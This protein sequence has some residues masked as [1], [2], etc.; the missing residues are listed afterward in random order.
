MLVAQNEREQIIIQ[1][2]AKAALTVEGDFAEV[3]VFKG[4][5]ARII[6]L[7]KGD[8]PLHLFD[9]FEGLPEPGNEDTGLLKSTFTA[10]LIEVK[11]HLNDY[12]N[13]HIYKGLFPETATPIKDKKFAFVHLDGD[14]Y[15]TTK[16]ALYFFYPRM[17]KGG[18]ILMHDYQRI[19]GVTKAIKEFFD[20]KPEELTMIGGC[21]CLV[22]KA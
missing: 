10:S 9:T 1:L 12:E 11:L 8:R 17:E 18:L 4:G 6:C 16:Q 19:K 5:S 13:V 7:A 14:L 20:K 21:Q 15:N 2:L 22:S 3:G